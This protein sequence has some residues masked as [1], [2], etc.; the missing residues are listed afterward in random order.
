VD[1]LLVAVCGCV[2]CGRHIETAVA[3]P[4]Q[5]AK[6]AVVM[7]SHSYDGADFLATLMQA[8][9]VQY[10]SRNWQLGGINTQSMIVIKQTY[11]VQSGDKLRHNIGSRT[12]NTYE[13]TH[14]HNDLPYVSKAMNIHIFFVTVCCTS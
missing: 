11:N 13:R 6:M 7:W 9:A 12:N 1:A 3:P 8:V 10:C 4:W 5:C 2:Q 14:T